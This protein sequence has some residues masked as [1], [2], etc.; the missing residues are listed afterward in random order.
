MK[1]LLTPLLDET[2][3]SGARE[4]PSPL[5][6]SLSCYLLMELWMLVLMC[7][8]PVPA[9]YCMPVFIYGESEIMSLH[10]AAPSSLSETE[11]C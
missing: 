11:I 5:W 10:S 3:V 6:K 2:R 1:Q 8:L 9:G 4:D 7:T